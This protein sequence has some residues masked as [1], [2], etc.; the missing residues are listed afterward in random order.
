MGLK[1]SGCSTDGCAIC[2]N[3]GTLDVGAAEGLGT[4]GARVPV[5]EAEVVDSLE[6][7]EV[8]EEVEADKVLVVVLVDELDVGVELE[9]VDA[10]VDVVEPGS[11]LRRRT[12]RS[13]AARSRR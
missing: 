9:L 2:F 5:D 7:E 12:R 1:L 3:R 11:C 6:E 4:A 8:D 10:G 13:L